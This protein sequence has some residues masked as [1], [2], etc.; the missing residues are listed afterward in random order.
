MANV[1][2]FGNSET[3]QLARYY[4]DNDSNHSV[5]AFTVNRDYLAGN[6][7][8]DGLPLVAFEDIQQLYP[9]DSNKFFAPLTAIRMNQVRADIYAKA[10]S[11]G[12]QCVSYISSRAT[13]LSESIGENCFIL[14]D[15]TIQPFVTIGDNVV[16]WSG[17][18]IGH[19]STLESHSFISSQVV[20]CGMCHIGEFSFLGVNSSI[21]DRVT[22]ATGSFICMASAVTQDTL[23]WKSYAGN[24][25]RQLNKDSL[26]MIL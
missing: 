6:A 12:Y 2:I 26:D 3:A 5:V 14:E 24:P 25:A 15:N 7:E 23:A 10:K 20:V 18:H 4:L 9:P 11:A 1:V 13:V 8:F 22:V 21:R 16:L 17:N 19:H